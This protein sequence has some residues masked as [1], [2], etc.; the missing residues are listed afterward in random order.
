MNVLSVISLFIIA[1]LGFI[2][3][4]QKFEI[5]LLKESEK[6]KDAKIK[7]LLSYVDSLTAKKVKKSK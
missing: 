4:R 7:S 5:T 2:I 3:V 6:D 1:V